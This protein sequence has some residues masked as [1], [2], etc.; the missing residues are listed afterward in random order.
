MQ[1]PIYLFSTS[2]HPDTININSL[3]I[4]FF[5]PEIEFEKYDYLIITSKQISTF[6]AQYDSNL[7]KPLKAL[8]VSKKSALAYEKIGG[9]VLQTGFGYGDNLSEI[10]KSYPKMTKWLYL[11]AEIV[12]SSFANDCREEGCQID[13]IVAYKSGCSDAILDVEVEDNAT[14][15]FTSPSSVECFLKGRKFKRTHKVV[16]I[17]KT[18]AAALPKEIFYHI[19]EET[20]V[21]SCVKLALQI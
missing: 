21:E 1:N 11:R 9:E 19:A 15:I 5:K 7:Y 2:S 18:T 13:E 12:A 10:I 17:G 20:S 14:L 6:L 3:Q 16:V 8:C 4:T